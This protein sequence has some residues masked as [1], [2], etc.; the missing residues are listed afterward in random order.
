M[1]RKVGKTATPPSNTTTLNSAAL[2]QLDDP[3]CR[4]AIA[5]QACSGPGLAILRESQAALQ[6]VSPETANKLNDLIG[7]L[8]AVTKAIS[9]GA[10]WEATSGWMLF[11]ADVQ[12]MFG[13]F[14]VRGEEGWRKVVYW[15]ECGE[16]LSRFVARDDG[17]SALSMLVARLARPIEERHLIAV[18]DR[19][20]SITLV[21][22]PAR[23]TVATLSELSE[24]EAVAVDGEPF[25]TKG[26]DAGLLAHYRARPRAAQRGLP[27]AGPLRMR[28][29]NRLA[30]GARA[31][32]LST[33]RRRTLTDPGRHVACGCAWL[34]IDGSDVNRRADR[35]VAVRREHCGEPET[36][37]GSVARL[38]PSGTHRLEDGGGT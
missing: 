25:V 32:E 5:R 19:A 6:P 37:L 33:Y 26:P 21:R 35:R 20:E 27:F 4:E 38:S 16:V 22:Q 12:P 14:R 2:T 11:K 29:P 31:S 34:R 9:D 8:E 3:T 15:W 1:K 13:T 18:T 30:R 17:L 28:T 23:V 10:S 24:L 36:V 7:A